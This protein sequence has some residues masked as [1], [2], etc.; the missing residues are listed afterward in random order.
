[1][2]SS[3]WTNRTIQARQMSSCCSP[4]CLSLHCMHPTTRT[5]APSV[6]GCSWIRRKAVTGFVG[7]KSRHLLR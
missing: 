2:A 4:G 1:M 5:R 6:V 3:T 7:V